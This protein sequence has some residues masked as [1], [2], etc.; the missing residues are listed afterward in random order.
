MVGQLLTEEIIK[1]F[2]E[3]LEDRK[4]ILRV[5]FDEGIGRVKFIS[6]E[7]VLDSCT[8]YV[9]DT[10]YLLLNKYL[11]DRYDL[12]EVNYNNTRTSFWLIG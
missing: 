8:A 5:T 10:F 2:N 7:L 11:K 1:G 9:T 6:D 3:M 12:S 4:S